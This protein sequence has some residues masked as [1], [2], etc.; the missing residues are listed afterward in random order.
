MKVLEAFGEPIADGGQESF[1]FGV[2]D[3]IDMTDLQIDCLTAYDCRSERYR[4]VVVN[5]GGKV[6]ALNLP[7]APGKS[8]ANIRAPFTAFLKH[9]HYDVVHIHSGSISVLA[10]MAEVADKAGVKKVIVHSHATGFSDSVKH[11]IIRYVGSLIMKKHVDDYLACSIEAAQWKFEPEFANRA[12]IIRNG[13]DIEKFVFNQEKRKEWRKKLRFAP[14]HYV[15]G[16]VGRFTKEKNHA[17]IIQLFEK[18]HSKCE[19]SRLLLVGDGDLKSVIEELARKKGLLDWIIF[20]GS[21]TNVSDYLHAMDAFILPSVYEGLPVSTIEAQAAGL[22]LVVSDTV[23]KEIDVTGNVCFLSINDIESWVDEL[24]RYTSSK[25]ANR[26]SM[27]TIDEIKKSGFSIDQAANEL[28]QIYCQTIQ[29][30]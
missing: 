27:S 4:S 16:H 2:I 24:Y 8:R 17:F 11:R 1:V 9:H 18:L 19:K 6:Y 20:A 7:F 3:K 12:V 29:G 13:V 14:E 21:V 28:R 15:I 30:K 10:I 5:R 22:P 25:T 26:N 23:T